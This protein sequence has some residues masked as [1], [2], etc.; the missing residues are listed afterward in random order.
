MVLLKRL[1]LWSICLHGLIII[2]AGHGVGVIF[3][4]DVFS[5]IDFRSFIKEE[6]FGLIPTSFFEVMGIAVVFSV[7]GKV[8]AI[9][10]L[11]I[12]KQRLFFFLS[13]IG[14]ANLWLSFFYLSYGLKYN[15]SSYISFISGFPF[16][17]LSVLFVVFAFLHIKNAKAV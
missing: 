1:L 8:L 15:N 3:I 13:V 16:L 10:A 11:F 6:N 17:G 2:A 4:L 9:V 7:I 5:I 12:K 14:L